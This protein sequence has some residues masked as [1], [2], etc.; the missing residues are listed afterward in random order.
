[1]YTRSVTYLLPSP[2]TTNCFDYNKIGCKSRQDCIDKCN[3]EW[4]L[5]H[6]NSL[7]RNI[8]VDKKNYKD[9]FLKSCSDTNYC[10][11]KYKSPDCS[12]Q[13]Y[14]I[15][16]MGNQKFTEFMTK[17][18]IKLLNQSLNRNDNLRSNK[19]PKKTIDINL[20]TLI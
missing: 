9:K 18:K 4:S 6:C 13:H 12:N 16:I 8:I 10:Q 14:S 2:Y 11:E 19:E 15:E 1:M 7:P 3:I 20:L 17:E 5:R